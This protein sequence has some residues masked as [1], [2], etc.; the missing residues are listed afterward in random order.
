[1]AKSLNSK[2]A[3]GSNST[4][5]IDGAC[6]RRFVDR[7][8]K[9]MEERS[10]LNEDLKKVY[11]EAK[12]AGYVTKQI[13]Q[14]CREQMLEPDLLRRHLEQMDALRHALGEFSATPLG[15]VAVAAELAAF[16][17]NLTPFDRR[18]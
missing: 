5:M 7:A 11:E 17:N 1:M 18:P 16:E 10:S 8:I 15:A 12:E 6:L 14:L 3:D 9:L 2:T 13:R 4:G